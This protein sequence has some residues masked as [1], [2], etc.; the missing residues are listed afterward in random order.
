MFRFYYFLLPGMFIFKGEALDQSSSQQRE[1][2]IRGACEGEEATNRNIPTPPQV[3]S[4]Y[5]SSQEVDHIAKERSQ[6]NPSSEKCGSKVIYQDEELGDT[7]AQ[8]EL[9]NNSYYDYCTSTN[10][11]SQTDDC[12][13]AT[14]PHY[15]ANCSR[16]STTHENDQQHMR[17]DIGY[18]SGDDD[19][20]DG[21]YSGGC[22]S[23]NS[24]CNK[25]H[26]RCCEFCIFA[27]GM[28]RYPHMPR[29]RAGGSRRD[30]GGSRAP[31]NE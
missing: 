5:R 26:G 18:F 15:H 19:Y 12:L 2:P 11:F 7:A 22:D 25:M 4:N 23:M 31:E 20:D 16:Y 6:D 13:Q 27:K 10:R 24:D 9:E 21:D 1:L 17:H 29:D 30:D 8:V 3:H 28:P 14:V